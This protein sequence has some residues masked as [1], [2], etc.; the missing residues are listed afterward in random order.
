[1]LH[2]HESLPHFR[3]RLLHN[4]KSRPEAHTFLL[5]TICASN[6]IPINRNPTRSSGYLRITAICAGENGSHI[7]RTRCRQCRRE[8]AV[9]APRRLRGARIPYATVANV[10]E[11]SGTNCQTLIRYRILELRQ[12][13]NRQQ[14]KLIMIAGVSGSTSSNASAQLPPIPPDVPPQVVV[15]RQ[16]SGMDFEEQEYMRRC[17]RLHGIA[18]CATETPKT[19][20]SIST[21]WH[22]DAAS[23]DGTTIV[24]QSLL[25]IERVR[26]IHAANAYWFLHRTCHFHPLRFREI[27][28]EPRLIG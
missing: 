25:T 20:D 1:M 2:M 17:W 6:S 12:L 22:E 14:L 21:L 13:T 18:N 26:D 28:R 4:Q 23:R 11:Y 9:S 15:E 7:D 19:R 8:S 24:P 5:D 16:I 10:F 3:T 27:L